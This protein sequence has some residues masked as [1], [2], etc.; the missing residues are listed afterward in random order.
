MDL[1]YFK[2]ERLGSESCSEEKTFVQSQ[3]TM[4][5]FQ[6]GCSNSSAFLGSVS[7]LELRIILE[8]NYIKEMVKGL[9]GP[10]T[11]LNG[12]GMGWDSLNLF[13]LSKSNA[14]RISLSMCCV[15]G[16]KVTHIP[17][18][19]SCPK[20]EA[21]DFSPPAELGFASLIVRYQLWCLWC[22]I[23]VP[24]LQAFHRS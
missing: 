15:I 24:C 19:S 13:F 3:I 22:G 2:P 23:T 8:K 10:W 4:C 16:C 9:L 21:G 5:V 1:T 18:R 7:A 11:H 6:G 20:A 12:T 14:S 17:Y